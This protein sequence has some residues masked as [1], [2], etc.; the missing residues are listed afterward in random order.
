MSVAG[1]RSLCCLYLNLPSWGKPKRT[2]SFPGSLCLSPELWGR[3]VINDPLEWQVWSFIYTTLQILFNLQV[4]IHAKWV[5]L[6]SPCGCCRNRNELMKFRD[7]HGC[8]LIFNNAPS[9]L[10]A[11]ETPQPPTPTP[12]FITVYWWY[13]Q[14]GSSSQW[15]THIY[16]TNEYKEM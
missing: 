11:G 3:F 8:V 15:L 2:P 1:L 7:D 12:G 9:G 6:L 14:T 13:I 16:Q 4:S 5:A 10:A